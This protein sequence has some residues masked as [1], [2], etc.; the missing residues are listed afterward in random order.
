MRAE[1][2]GFS[3][4]MVAKALLEPDGEDLPDG[5]GVVRRVRG[6]LCLVIIL[7]PTPFRGACLVTT[8]IRLKPQ[9]KAK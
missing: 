1:Q 5:I 2:E 8:I 7:K 6:L 4:E 3:E 9:A